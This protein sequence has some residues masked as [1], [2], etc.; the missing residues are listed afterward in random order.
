LAFH[1]VAEGLIAQRTQFRGRYFDRLVRQS[2]IAGRW[3]EEIDWFN[4]LFEG[5]NERMIVW[6]FTNGSFSRFTLGAGG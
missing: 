2:N 5:T 6:R 4:D 3:D 1:Q